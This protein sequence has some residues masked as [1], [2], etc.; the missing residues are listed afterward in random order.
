MRRLSWVSLSLLACR[1]SEGP[2]V[3]VSELLA[4]NATGLTDARGRHSDWIEVWNSGTE[5]DEL[6]GYALSYEGRSFALPKRTIGPGE[7]VVF[8]ASEEELGFTLKKRGELILTSRSGDRSRILLP[9]QRQDVS[10][11]LDATGA[12]AYFE[13]PTP[14]APPEGP[15]FRGHL[16]RPEVVPPGGIYTSTVVVELRSRLGQIRY[17]LDGSDPKE[18]SPY[19]EPI[20]LPRRGAVVLRSLAF[21]P[22]L[23]TSEVAT[24]TYVFPS[25]VAGNAQSEGLP[26]R[27]GRGQFVTG[28][29][30][31]MDPR[32]EG[33]EAA[34]RALPTVSIVIEPD[35]LF[36]P[37][38]GIYSNPQKTGRKWER[39]ASIEVFGAGADVRVDAALRVQGSSAVHAWRLKKLSFRARFDRRFGRMRFEHDLFGDGAGG[40]KGF[41]LEAQNNNTWAHPKEIERARAQYVR[42]A[43]VA[44]LMREVGLVAPRWRFVHAYLDGVYWGVYAITER[45]DAHF[46]ALRLGGRPRDYDVVRQD[47]VVVAGS[48]DGFHEAMALAE[49][50]DLA[51]LER[52]VDVAAFIDYFLVNLY[53]G[54]T[55]WPDR[56]WYAIR[57]Q[58][59]KWRFITWD[60]E[61][62]LGDVNA[63]LD[64]W[65]AAGP[66]KLFLALER[67]AAFRAAFAKRARE[68]LG[69][70]GVLRERGRALYEARASSVQVALVAESARWGDVHRA[71][72]YRVDVEWRAERDRLLRSWFPRRP[73]VLIG[74]LRR[75]GLW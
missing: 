25:R 31:A 28:A 70:G 32:I 4:S 36:H 39:R 57:K 14:G 65:G 24:H 45:P 16:P 48:A 73:D 60:A 33:V 75:R 9:A 74:Q 41:M 30:Y 52:Q 8:F 47:A 55:D 51:A 18:G 27:W 68:L 64:A 2:P 38:R 49:K 1:A 11:G 12:L 17:T 54:N 22:D 58:G 10:Y 44:D 13:R 21:A 3:V 34:L 7:R 69:P 67:H 71:E 26:E 6:E 46:A 59:E 53:A 62:V 72:P 19:T 66:A 20:T 5:A 43:F 61:Q 29:D 56:N 23:M 40:W 42:D 35:D 37:Y 63:G 15:S 50:G